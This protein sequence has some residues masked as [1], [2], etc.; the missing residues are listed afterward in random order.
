MIIRTYDVL[1]LFCTV[2]SCHI[3]LS[4]VCMYVHTY[5]YVYVY[6]FMHVYVFVSTC[7]Y[8]YICKYPKCMYVLYIGNVDYYP[9][10]Y[11][12]CLSHVKF[13]TIRSL[14]CA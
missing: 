9:V 2:T 14:H 4:L 11:R 7:T 8:I 3:Y 10:S 1:F 12:H 5:V 13:F 6:A